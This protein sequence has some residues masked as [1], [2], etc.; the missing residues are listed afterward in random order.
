MMGGKFL[1]PDDA[2][3]LAQFGVE[4]VAVDGEQ[5]TREVRI[6]VP[7][8][9]E[10]T[11]SYDVILGSVRFAWTAAGSPVAE[12]YREGACHLGI[13]SRSGVTLVRAEF[14]LGSLHGTLVLQVYPDIRLTDQLLVS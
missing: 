14:S 4:P 7:G 12:L 8:G 2:E 11:I 1:V 10:V 9:Q 5:T 3:W 6:A 13:E